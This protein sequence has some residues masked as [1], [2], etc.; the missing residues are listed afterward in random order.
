MSINKSYVLAGALVA[1]SSIVMPIA[2]TSQVEA[3]TQTV[4]VT[5]RVNFRKGP[6]MNYSIMRKLY[7]GYKLTYLGK[8]GNWIKVKYDGTTGYVYKDYV[9]GY[10][11]S[12]DNKGITRYVNASV[13]LNV[14][15]GPSTS[16]SKLG[17]LSYGKSVKV[18]STSNGWS[19]IIYNGRTAYVKSTYLQ[20]KKPSSTS[21]KND[22][23]TNVS[24]SVSALISYAKRFLGKPYVWGA[25]GPN[26]FDC[27]G[28]TYYVFKNSAN[29]TLPRTSKD[30]STCGTTISK[31]NLKVGDLV[32]FDTS[33]SNSGNVSHVGIYIGSNQFIHA[34]SSKGKVVI[35]DFNNYYTNAFVKVKRVL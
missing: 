23:D 17:K 13:G 5:S 22:S 21:S 11:S 31:K 10:S 33:G 26:S 4:T 20:A 29:I 34:S 12:S 7:K 25:Q 3:A 9:S 1:T 24:K 8:N 32:F 6:S 2:E 35:S 15:K 14:R 28:F 16:Y 19:K 18:L 27:S 30:Q